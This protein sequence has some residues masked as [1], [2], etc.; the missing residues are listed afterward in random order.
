[1]GFLSDIRSG[2]RDR[3]GLG[4]YAVIFWVCAGFIAGG[5]F[6][7]YLAG[8]SE[9]AALTFALAG[10]AIGS[11]LGFYAAFARTSV[12]RVLALPGFLLAAIGMLVG[13]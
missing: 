11:G 6:G 9:K 13:L 2:K 8:N 1:M 4:V 10:A 7:T 3:D 12:A 5:G